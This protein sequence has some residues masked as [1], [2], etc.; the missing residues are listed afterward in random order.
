MA[1][2]RPA[3]V[4]CS[5]FVYDDKKNTFQKLQDFLFDTNTGRT[6]VVF[7]ASSATAYESN[8]HQYALDPDNYHYT[9]GLIDGIAKAIILGSD[10][11]TPRPQYATDVQFAYMCNKIPNFDR[12]NPNT[13]V[14]SN[15][16]GV[17]GYLG[18]SSVAYNSYNYYLINSPGVGNGN[19][20]NSNTGFF[21]ISLNMPEAPSYLVSWVDPNDGTILDQVTVNK[22]DLWAYSFRY[23]DDV[24]TNGSTLEHKQKYVTGL[25][26]FTSFLL[27]EER[28]K[29][30]DTSL[31]FNNTATTTPEQ[32][33]RFWDRENSWY[34]GGDSAFFLIG[35]AYI[36][37]GVIS[38]IFTDALN[39]GYVPA[40]LAV[41]Q[42][43][44]AAKNLLGPGQLT[45]TRFNPTE[46]TGIKAGFIN[47]TGEASPGQLILTH[48]EWIP[49]N[50]TSNPGFINA[51]SQMIG[52]KKILTRRVTLNEVI[53]IRNLNI[54]NNNSA[55][56]S[57][58]AWKNVDG[59]R[60]GSNVVLR[61]AFANP[62]TDAGAPQTSPNT[63]WITSVLERKYGLATTASSSVSDWQAGLPYLFQWGN[64]STFLSINGWDTFDWSIK[65]SN[66]QNT[67]PTTTNQLVG[68]PRTLSTVAPSGFFRLGNEDSSKIVSS[69]YTKFNERCMILKTNGGLFFNGI[70]QTGSE[71]Q[72]SAALLPN[73][74][75]KQVYL[76]M[77]SSASFKYCVNV[78]TLSKGVSETN[79]ATN[80]IINLTAHTR[81]SA[82]GAE[83]LRARNRVNIPTDI[84]DPSI[85]ARTVKKTR[86]ELNLNLNTINSNY[87]LHE[88]RLGF[89]GKG[90]SLDNLTRGDLM[91][92][93]HYGIDTANQHGIAFS[94]LDTT[95][96][97]RSGDAGYQND[98]GG[99]IAGGR[100][101]LYLEFFKDI[102][103][104]QTDPTL[105]AIPS[106]APKLVLMFE[107]G[108]WELANPGF[109][110]NGFN[111]WTYF[112][113]ELPLNSTGT[114]ALGS[115]G[116]DAVTPLINLALIAGFSRQNI[117]VC[118]YTPALLTRVTTPSKGIIEGISY[119]TAADD[120]ALIRTK[121]NR[122]SFIR[123][124]EIFVNN[125][126]TLGCGYYNP[127][128]PY[129]NLNVA[130]PSAKNSV[131]FNIN[132]I[133]NVTT[134]L[135]NITGF[136]NSWYDSSNG[137]VEYKYYS[138]EG[139]LALGYVA[140]EHLAVSSAPIYFTPTWVLPFSSM[141]NY[142]TDPVHG[143]DFNFVTPTLDKTDIGNY[144]TE[145]DILCDQGNVQAKRTLSKFKT[146]ILQ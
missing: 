136:E 4:L 26:L 123:S 55:I 76:P 61:S 132:S 82:T 30:L 47:D 130:N 10:N 67:G 18:C 60:V 20:T 8:Q 22:K 28:D 73:A 62:L 23:L 39:Y 90:D 14:A 42:T 33:Q 72:A 143:V 122:G 106:V 12:W 2:I 17:G 37:N 69:A 68:F 85:N 29:A 16:T 99:L 34:A 93:T 63:A 144:Y 107:C 145:L 84:I 43:V 56:T 41:N 52:T 46:S 83:T 108:V 71:Y 96:A 65:A 44:A 120:L 103:N 11:R 104:R 9:G 115:F 138:P 87:T 78:Y 102:L 110:Y 79:I 31:I 91:I 88:I 133:P 35:I 116:F 112:R 146:K 57:Y 38:E 66:N 59:F 3:G 98:S 111:T 140:M 141:L 54:A 113:D 105:G 81:N 6:D 126:I 118:F 7:F 58:S 89:L 134:Y 24:A 100:A 109:T 127:C 75:A 97:Y 135:N 25:S 114:P 1:F 139:A 137:A 125:F 129:P 121:N 19:S 50:S 36:E 21:P 5:N 124:S 86:C 142:T 45:V 77:F 70:N 117:V 94:K 51:I 92:T 80:N 101:P 74:A 49:D 119:N 13:W 128:P 15:T 27:N 48:S 40:G 32:P 95:Y 131:Y 64:R 53:T